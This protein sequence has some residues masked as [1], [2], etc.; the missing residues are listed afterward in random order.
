MSIATTIQALQAVHRAISG[1][2]SAPDGTGTY[3]IP[4]KIGN[5]ALPLVLLFPAAV[6]VTPATQDDTNEVRAYEGI[7]ICTPDPVGVGVNTSSTTIWTVLD[8][9]K[10]RYETMLSTDERIDGNRAMV[11]S[12]HDDGQRSITYRGINWEGFLF[13]VQVWSTT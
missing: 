4:D 7:V 1:V 10:A 6:D 9:F 2:T 8:A 11:M 5:E 13:R 3:P 12:Y